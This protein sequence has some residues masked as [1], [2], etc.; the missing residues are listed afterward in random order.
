MLPASHPIVAFA[1]V[2]MAFVLTDARG[3]EP[4]KSARSVHAATADTVSFPG[5]TLAVRRRESETTRAQRR[6]PV[7]GE[8]ETQSAPDARPECGPSEAWMRF[9]LARSRRT[10]VGLDIGSSLVKIVEIDHGRSTPT[11]VR[12]G[13]V[14]LPP[15]AIVDG[16]VMDRLLVLDAVRE[17]IA[18]SGIKSK[19]VVSAVSGRALIVKK[20]V[21]DKMNQEDAQEAIHWEA[22]QHVP[23][24]IDDVC[25]DFQ[26]L[27]D[28]IGNNQMQVL[29]VAAKKEAIHAHADLVR[30]AGL[31]PL[32]IDV[33]AFAVQ[34]CYEANYDTQSGRV[35]GLLNVGSET[36]NLN[37]VQN[38]VP[39]FT[40]DLSVGRSRF[41]EEVQRDCNIGK[42]E[43]SRMLSQMPADGGE[44]DRLR[45]TVRRTA[46]ELSL[47]IERSFA[48]L[49]GSGEADRLDGLMLSGGGA[50]MPL[51][52]EFLAERH[53]VSTEVTDPLRQVSYDPELFTK[54]SV[55]EVAPLLAVGVGLGLRRME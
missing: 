24:D 28:S 41:V 8:R 42:D 48:F 27:N 19:D 20:V 54:Q 15:E 29:L 23:F 37:I 40:R 31:H 35:V 47:G 44:R 9:S 21:M 32:V 49:K 17:C 38:G 36:S 16:E 4:R 55:D 25:L 1:G 45:E 43:A 18:Q 51:L 3:G 30:D 33:D 46:E 39:Q 13:I 14:P 52:R 11:L 22:E 2:Q 34:N 26:I 50:A 53:G 10:T 7:Q 6:S 5:T 12:V